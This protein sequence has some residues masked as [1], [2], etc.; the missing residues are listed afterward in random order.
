MGCP[1]LRGDGCV[2]PEG[3]GVPWGGSHCNAHHWGD[4]LGMWGGPRGDGTRLCVGGVFMAGV[5]WGAG[6]PWSFWVPAVGSLGVSPLVW[7]YLGPRPPG[8]P[9]ARWSW[10]SP[11]PRV[12]PQPRHPEA[13]GAAPQTGRSH[14][15]GGPP[16][17]PQRPPLSRT[18]PQG[19]RTTPQR[20]VP[21]GLRR[22]R[23]RSRTPPRAA[24]TPLVH[25]WPRPPGGH[26]GGCGGPPGG[27]ARCGVRG[28]GG[29]PGEPPSAA[30]HSRGQREGQW[31][32]PGGARGGR[33]ASDP[34]S[35][36]V[37]RSR[38]AGTGEWLGGGGGEGGGMTLLGV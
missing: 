33:A 35:N 30:P 6:F 17:L 14:G 32:C 31:C 23:P 9:P 26:F 34:R 3:I 38:D 1:S 25:R 10:G 22:T 16:G 2:G 4:V 11:C 19:Q 8:F 21:G 7:G 27:R 12:P 5:L 13:G 18:Q 29:H 37:P 24:R 36:A 20:G 28:G 15:A